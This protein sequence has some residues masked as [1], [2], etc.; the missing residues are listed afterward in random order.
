M[1][2]AD[3]NKIWLS[4]D[5]EGSSRRE[6]RRGIVA[7]RADWSMTDAAALMATMR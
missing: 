2:A 7:A 5:A 4:D 6:T 1:I 3:W